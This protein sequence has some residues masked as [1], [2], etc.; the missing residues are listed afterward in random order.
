MDRDE[1]PEECELE[2]IR[3]CRHD[4]MALMRYVQN[5]W[6]WGE[7]WYRYELTNEYHEFYFATGGWSG[8]EDLIGA[9]KENQMFWLVCWWRSERGGAFWF[10]LNL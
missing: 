5:R 2:F 10:R 7:D 9:L 6:H 8:N 1:Y 4:Y 3:E